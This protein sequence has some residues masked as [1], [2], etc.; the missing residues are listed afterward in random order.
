MTIA[1]YNLRKAS[2]HP[3][4]QG[5]SFKTLAQEGSD[6]TVKKRWSQD[7]GYI[8]SFWEEV[9]SAIFRNDMLLCLKDTNTSSG[10]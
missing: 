6:P 10:G 2:K 9:T 3:E 8:P 1:F 4:S 5:K 7:T